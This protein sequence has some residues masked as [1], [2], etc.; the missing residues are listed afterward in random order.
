[1]EN[2]NDSTRLNKY[3]ALH[4]GVSRREADNLI[5]TGNVSINGEMA[6]IGSRVAP[7]DIVAIG[8]TTVDNTTSY[9]Y[10]MLHK[11]IGYVCS[12]LAQGDSP[13][14]YSILPDKYHALKSVGRLDRDTSGLIILTNDGDFAQQMTHP[15]FYKIKKYIVTLDHDLQPLHHQMIND[16]GVNLDDG[17]SQLTLERQTEGD[18]RNWIITMSEGRNRQIRRTFDAL[19]Y[20]VTRLHRTDFG[21][22]TLGDLKPGAIAVVARL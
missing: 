18:S 22:Y 10:I 3:L 14:I 19:G 4:K 11:P 6:V 2:D 12:R 8:D 16:I 17:K 13:T 15:K 1:M 5:A 20:T 21:N 9:Q 7:G